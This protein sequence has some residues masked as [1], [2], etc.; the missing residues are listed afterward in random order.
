MA[1]YASVE[2]SIAGQVMRLLC[3]LYSDHA[4]LMQLVTFNY[5]FAVSR[6]MLPFVVEIPRRGGIKPS[7]I[8]VIKGYFLCGGNEVPLNIEPR[9]ALEQFGTQVELLLLGRNSS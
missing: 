6:P 8:S 3:R 7:H 2:L 4:S 9:K 1:I 5:V